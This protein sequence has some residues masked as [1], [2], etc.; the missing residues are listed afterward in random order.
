MNTIEEKIGVSMS[1]RLFG[2]LHLARHE[3][4]AMNVNRIANFEQQKELYLKNAINL[5]K[6]LEARGISFTLLTNMKSEIHDV[7]KRIKCSYPL[8]VEYIDCTR[9]VPTGIRFYSAHYKLDAF[10]F[11][12]SLENEQYTGLIDLDM[13][14]LSDFPQCWM[15][16][17][18]ERIPICYDIS[19]QVIPAYGHAI[20]IKDM[21]ELF[22]NVSEGR[23]CGGEFIS[24]P[25]TF[26][27][28]LNKE[29]DSIYEY[30]S[31]S[32]ETFHHHG[33]ELV[34]SVALEKLRRKGVCIADGGTIGI[35]G[36][37]WSAPT[38]HPQKPFSYFKNCFLLHLPSDKEFLADLSNEATE[39]KEKFIKEYE[40]VK[41]QKQLRIKC[42]QIFRFCLKIAHR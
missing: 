14:A 38:L 6:S 20:I 7:L 9:N 22:Q 26:F 1:I 12:A 28:L 25:P 29:I 30:Y 3:T 27:S 18:K 10:R 33:D 39:R 19:D 34:T 37:F 17:I 21:Q 11:L 15:N 40:T 5:S 2:L 23:W 32:F 41:W 8:N 4:S 24:G 35:I 31:K 13:I 42:G 16:L 36:R